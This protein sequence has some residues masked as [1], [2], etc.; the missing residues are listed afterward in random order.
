MNLKDATV[1]TLKEFA[2]R[3][4]VRQATHTGLWGWER[5]YDCI[6]LRH[7]VFRSRRDA[8]RDRAQAFIQRLTRA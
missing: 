1:T 4:P 3:Y 2:E 6:D 5:V 8:E 7:C